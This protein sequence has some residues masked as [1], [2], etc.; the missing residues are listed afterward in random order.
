MPAEAGGEAMGIG[1]QPAPGVQPTGLEARGWLEGTR[2]PDRVSTA[3]LLGATTSCL[4]FGLFAL[5]REFGPPGRAWSFAAMIAG[6]LTGPA[7]GLLFVDQDSR[8]R[9]SGSRLIKDGLL[10]ALI[11]VS[12]GILLFEFLSTL[13][14][15]RRI[16][17][18]HA[19]AGWWSLPFIGTFTGVLMRAAARPLWMVMVLF[20]FVAGIVWLAIELLTS[21]W[22]GITAVAAGH[23]IAMMTAAVRLPPGF[24]DDDRIRPLDVALSALPFIGGAALIVAVCG[25]WSLPP[26]W[27][28]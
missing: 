28:R 12:A 4:S 22:T 27:R 13:G 20:H 7:V 2:E 6:V 23:A 21:P 9:L 25:V 18:L 3:A 17:R 16:L 26:Y 14:A 19:L 11:L 10:G 5:M 24:E 15:H 8:R 1:M